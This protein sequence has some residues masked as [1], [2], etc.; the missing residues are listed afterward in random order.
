MTYGDSYNTRSAPHDE[1]TGA[2]W[3]IM[4]NGKLHAHA[5]TLGAARAL[6]ARTISYAG[7]GDVWKILDANGADH[8]VYF[9]VGAKVIDCD[10]FQGTIVKITEWNGSRWYDVRFPRGEAVRYEADLTLA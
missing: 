9:R 8:N 10:G 7:A 2:G 1:A 5:E 4:R 6:V 3:Q